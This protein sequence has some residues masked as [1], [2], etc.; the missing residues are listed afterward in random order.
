MIYIKNTVG[1]AEQTG[2]VL[3]SDINVMENYPVYTRNFN[4]QMC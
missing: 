4:M 2:Q 1:L 3:V